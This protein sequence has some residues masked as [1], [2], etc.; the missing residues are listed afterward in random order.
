MRILGEDRSDPVGETGALEQVIHVRLE[1]Q[2]DPAIDRR[3]VSV[4]LVDGGPQI[5]RGHP[6]V[7]AE[8]EDPS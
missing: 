8:L 7:C 5:A 1:I 3:D 6:V 2:G 4:D